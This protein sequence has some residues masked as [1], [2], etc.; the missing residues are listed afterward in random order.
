MPSF[1]THVKKRRVRVRLTRQWDESRGLC[2]G[3]GR[4]VVHLVIFFAVVLFVFVSLVVH[5][6][7]VRIV[8][9]VG[10]FIVHLVLVNLVALA[11]LSVLVSLVALD[12][13]S[14]LVMGSSSRSDR[15]RELSSVCLPR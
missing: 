5:F 12:V 4:V 1:G 9:V 7:V 6:F 14:V 11:V 8:S 15:Q 3:R 13:L 2:G 10:L